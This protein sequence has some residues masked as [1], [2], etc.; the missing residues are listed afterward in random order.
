M[1][2]AQPT[3]LLGESSGIAPAVVEV[4]A[5]ARLHMGFIDP[6]GLAGR[7]FGS[8]GMAID[9]PSTRVRVSAAPELQV[10]GYESERAERYL[11]RLLVARG[12][13]PAL[14]VEVREAMPAHAGLG[15]GTQLA[16]A[17]GAALGAW[18]DEP[19]S[20]GD[21]AR[22]LDRG[23]RSGIGVGAFEQGGFLL[24]GGKGPTGAPPPLVARCELPSQWRVLLIY[25]LA[26]RGL[27]GSN[28]REAFRE[29]ARR[30]PPEAE[31]LAALVLLGLLPAAVEGDIAAFGRAITELQ[32]R[33]GDHF[34]PVQGGRFASAAVAE[35]L[36][37]MQKQG[38][39]GVGQSSWGPT[40]FG[41]CE[42]ETRAQRLMELLRSRRRAGSSLRFQIVQPRNEPGLVRRLSGCSDDNH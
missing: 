38:A 42:D 2:H 19:V 36:A 8:V 32:Q 18:F 7:R 20:A 13:S 21:T 35:V 12:W 25:D 29:L 6:A 33:I 15:S 9:R 16:I 39:C 17:L 37:W 14:R 23:G 40:G 4:T 34:A 28:E 3:R 22:L 1:D 31:S 11:A 30:S 41:L 26:H 24:D 27:S 10:H 5:P